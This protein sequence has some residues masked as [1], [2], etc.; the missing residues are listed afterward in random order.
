[1]SHCVVE[2]ELSWLASYTDLRY[3]FNAGIDIIHKSF[4]LKLFQSF[5]NQ[6]GFVEIRHLKQT[7][8]R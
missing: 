7:E 6:V 1:M 5:N 8:E 2:Y 4:N 3:I